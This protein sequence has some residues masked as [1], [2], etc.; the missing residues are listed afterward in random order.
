[1]MDKSTSSN[2]LVIMKLT[3]VFCSVYQ[4]EAFIYVI[5]KYSS[6]K[7]KY[8]PV[9][10]MVYKSTDHRKLINYIEALCAKVRGKSS[11]LT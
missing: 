11:E 8:E 2:L 1:M 7:W 6:F 3:S 9:F 5:L 4:D 10:S